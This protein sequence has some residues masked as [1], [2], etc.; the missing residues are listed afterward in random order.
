MYMTKQSLIFMSNNR[1]YY[2]LTLFLMGIVFYLLNYFTPLAGDD[3]AYCFYFDNFSTDVRPTPERVTTFA[4]AWESMWN[5]YQVVNGRFISHL[6]I[7][8]FCALWGKGLFNV[9]NTMV[10]MAFL[11]VLVLLSGHKKSVLVLSLAFAVSLWVLPFPGQTMLWMTGAINYLWPTTF[12]L[13]MVYGLMKYCPKREQLWKHFVTFVLGVLIAWTNESVSAPVSFGLFIYYL[14]N[15]KQF[16]GLAR[17]SFLGYALGAALIIFSPGTFSRLNNDNTVF[18]PMGVDQLLFLHSYHTIYHLVI[19]VLP[20]IVLIGYL[21]LYIRNYRAKTFSIFHS[22]FGCIFL[23]F[24]LFLWALGMDDALRVFFGV[25]SF[26]FVILLHWSHFI[27]GRLSCNKYIVVFSI[28]ITILPSYYAIAATQTYFEAD[29]QAREMVMSAP[30]A[31][32]IQQQAVPE[33]NRFCYYGGMETLS[34]DRHAFHTRVKAFYYHKDYIQAL[35]SGVY[36]AWRNGNL[37]HLESMH[38]FALSPDQIAQ[39]IVSAKYSYPDTSSELRPHQRVIRRLL[40]TLSTTSTQSA[41]YID[42][43][44]VSYLI[45]PKDKDALKIEVPVLEDGQIIMKEFENR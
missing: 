1:Y 6:I 28:A 43:D 36:E 13:W 44:S 26:S 19:T 2:P 17:S 42:Q 34:P 10:F 4:M 25:A 23:A 22:L 18:Q 37:L 11:Q 16:R 31:C 21:I 20:F 24:L 12:A 15:Q 27:V 14:A 40:N 39:K 29:A 38:T 3:Y 35:P 30:K 41:Y 7:Q 9:I 33:S 45:F 5:H 8:C 32:V